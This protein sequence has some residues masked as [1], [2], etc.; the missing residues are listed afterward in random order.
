MHKPRQVAL[1]RAVR[2]TVPGFQGHLEFRG[3]REKPKPFDVWQR[4][5]RYAHPDQVRTPGQLGG[6]TQHR[7]EAVE[8]GFVRVRLHKPAHFLTLRRQ[9]GQI[10]IEIVRGHIEQHG[11]A[12]AAKRKEPLV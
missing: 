6:P 4:H 1:P 5:V 11:P 12:M 10:R 8:R 7:P 3:I 9:D 2:L